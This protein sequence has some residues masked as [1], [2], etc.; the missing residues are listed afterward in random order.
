MIP[1]TCFPQVSI[2]VSVSISFTHAQIYARI[3]TC[4]HIPIHTHTHTHTHTYTYTQ[5]HPHTLSH[6]HPYDHLCTKTQTHVHWWTWSQSVVEDENTDVI[7]SFWVGAEEDQKETRH[8]AAWESFHQIAGT[9]GRITCC[10]QFPRSLF[11]D[12][13]SLT[14]LST[15]LACL[16]LFLAPCTSQHTFARCQSRT[17]WTI[18]GPRTCWLLTTT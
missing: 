4:N 7:V 8:K 17:M 12:T 14:S 11:A 5:I 3:F 9:F 6:S 13:R 15:S 16:I 2:P 1:L 18:T 10:C